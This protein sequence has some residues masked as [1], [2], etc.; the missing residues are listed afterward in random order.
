[1]IRYSVVMEVNVREGG[2]GQELE[3][4]GRGTGAEEEGERWE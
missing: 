4:R 1:M 2:E 3:R